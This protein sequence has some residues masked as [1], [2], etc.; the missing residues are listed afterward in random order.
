MKKNVS[1][2]SIENYHSDEFQV[3]AAKQ[4]DRIA[5]YLRS[6]TQPV[7]CKEIARDLGIETATVSGQL[8]HMRGIGV[9][10]SGK[11]KC[12]VSGRIVHGHILVETSFDESGQG[13]I[14]GL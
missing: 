10:K 1:E 14:R 2:T 13:L 5:A 6:K 11:I 3:T 8:W 9:E 4:R 12:P 7:S